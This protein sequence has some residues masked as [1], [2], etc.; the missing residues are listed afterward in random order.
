MDAVTICS[1]LRAKNIN[2]VTVSIVSPSIYHEVMGP[3][4]LTLFF[5]C[6]FK[7]DFSLSSFTFIKRL[8][9]SPSQSAIMVVLPAYLRLLIF[10]PEILIL[11]CA[12]SGLAFHMMY[13]TYK[14]NTQDDNIQRWHT[15]FP[16]WKQSTVPCPVLTVAFWPV[17]RFLRR[18]VRW[19]GIPISLGIF[20]FV[21]IHTVESFSV[22]NVAE[23][24]VLLEF[25]CFF[26]WSSACWKFDIYFLCF[27]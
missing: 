27:F 10:L 15:S 5:E 24:D 21:V 1:D 12:S 26:F 19:S 14:L 3:E 25:C 9:N 8:F 11:A 16:I 7:P 17:Y 20:Q 2:S 13:S 22:V 4:R 23:V 6:C 18:Q